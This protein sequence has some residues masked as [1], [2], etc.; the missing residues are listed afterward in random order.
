MCEQDNVDQ[1]LYDF[2][3]M[4]SKAY[5]PAETRHRR[6]NSMLL[7][8]TDVIAAVAVNGKAQPSRTKAVPKPPVTP[9]VKKQ[10]AI[11]E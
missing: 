6:K 8:S 2:A 4:K 7:S 9:R 1:D 11:I 3:D 10:H 5:R